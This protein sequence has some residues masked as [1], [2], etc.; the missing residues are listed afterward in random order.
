MTEWLIAKYMPDL[1]RREPQN[2]GVVL[3]SGSSVLARFVAEDPATL[4]IDGRTARPMFG[5]WENYCD[6]VHFWRSSLGNGAER[7]LARRAGENYFLER[8]GQ[9]LA[10][11]ERDPRQLLDELYSMLV[12]EIDPEEIPVLAEPDPIDVLFRDVADTVA[13]VTP[14]V[15]D[16][17]YDE[18]TFDFA[19]EAD[20]THVF[21]R[22]ILNGNP[23]KTWEAV[24]GA[25]YSVESVS[26]REIY[27]PHILVVEKDPGP[28][29]DKQMRT[30]EHRVPHM[31]RRTTGD[32]HDRD[33]LLSLVAAKILP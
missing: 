9:L 7:L 2:I 10:G 26:Q 21:K 3:F 22:V 27:Q 25:V 24:H 31:L 1:R 18:L 30:L 15:V 32:Q 33:W 6:W 29:R 12:G 13:V 11:A 16:L 5:S 20:K 23:K 8:G 4:M 19:I 17:S 14:Y 28:S